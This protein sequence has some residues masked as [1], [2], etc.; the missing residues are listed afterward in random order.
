MQVSGGAGLPGKMLTARPSGIR[1]CC[2]GYCRTSSS[3]VSVSS[4]SAASVAASSLVR[5]GSSISMSPLIGP[6]L[7]WVFTF[8]STSVA[9]WHIDWSNAANAS[10]GQPV[11]ADEAVIHMNA[12]AV[13]WLPRHSN[14]CLNSYDDT[15]THV[16]SLKRCA[17]YEET[18]DGE[19]YDTIDALEDYNKD[20]PGPGD[21]NPYIV[22]KGNVFVMGDNRN[23]SH[24]SRFWGP[25]PLENIKGKAMVIWWSAA[26]PG[27]KR[28]WGV[29]WDR[30][31]HVVD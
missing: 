19:K 7:V 15:T 1:F 10:G 14:E 18:L 9:Y 11:A 6:L 29:R 16:W 28:T 27:E 20:F 5:N 22:P 24:D 17:K 13:Q 23:N 30:L 12:S 31:G 26:G 4:G 8:S 3:T 2:C 21:P 25:V